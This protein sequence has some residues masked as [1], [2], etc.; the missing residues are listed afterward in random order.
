MNILSQKKYHL[1]REICAPALWS[2]AE[3]TVM[4]SVMKVL[5]TALYISRPT[6]SDHIHTTLLKASNE[7]KRTKLPE[8]NFFSFHV[9]NT[10][11]ALSK[12]DEQKKWNLVTRAVFS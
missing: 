2:I 3:E 9:W 7:E 1:W 10:E 11:K 8:N 6:D 5:N 12:P 4:E